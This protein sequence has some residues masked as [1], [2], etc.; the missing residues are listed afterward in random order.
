MPFNRINAMSTSAL[1]PCLRRDLS[2]GLQQQMFFWGQDVIRPTGNFLKEQGFQRSPSK[3]SK[4]TSCYRLPWQDGHIELYGACAGWY[5]REGGFTFIRPRR[6]CYL[7]TSAHETP[8]PGALQNHHLASATQRDLYPAALPFLDWV[9]AHE[10]AV[11]SR[12]GESYRQENFR[13]Y[14][15]VPKARQWIEPSAALQWFKCLRDSPANLERPKQ[16]LQRSYA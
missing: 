13:Q 12:F 9:I 7:W 4:G 6:L 11:L 14:R 2:D 15:K 5:G 3:G 8:T 1:S 10:E 16:Y